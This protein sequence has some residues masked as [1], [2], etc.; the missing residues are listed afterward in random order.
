MGAEEFKE[1]NRE[2]WKT[3]TGGI[4]SSVI[5]LTSIYAGINHDT[6]FGMALLICFGLFLQIP[7]GYYKIYKLI[8]GED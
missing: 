5:G 4:I 8:V 2:I 7:L 6:F 3:W 1:K